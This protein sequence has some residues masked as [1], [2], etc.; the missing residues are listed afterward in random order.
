MVNADKGCSWY[1]IVPES[2]R[3]DISLTKKIATELES[4]VHV[5]NEMTEETTRD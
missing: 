2:P 1:P 5:T 3:P 4:G